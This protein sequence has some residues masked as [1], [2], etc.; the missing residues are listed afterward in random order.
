[1]PVLPVGPLE[2]G[3]LSAPVLGGWLIDVGSWRMIFLINVPIAIVAISFAF[4]SVPKD[5]VGKDHH[6]MVQAPFWRQLAL[7]SRRGH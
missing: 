4:L 1:M 6:S 3:Q 7:A 2:F 5:D